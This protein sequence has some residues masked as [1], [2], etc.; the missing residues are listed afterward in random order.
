MAISVGF[1]ANVS[2]LGAGEGD[3]DHRIVEAR[4]GTAYTCIC[5]IP[6]TSAAEKDV[7][8]SMTAKGGRP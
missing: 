7:A 4:L 6:V 3:R 1:N 2:R 8:A 5:V